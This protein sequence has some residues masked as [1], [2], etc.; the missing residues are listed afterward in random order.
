MLPVLHPPTPSTLPLLP[1]CSLRS[2]HTPFPKQKQQ[3][4][5]LNLGCIYVYNTYR[6][7][8]MEMELSLVMLYT[9]D[10]DQDKK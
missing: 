4:A 8:R 3:F 7:L 5:I 6:G 1:R 2:G 9:L 10:R